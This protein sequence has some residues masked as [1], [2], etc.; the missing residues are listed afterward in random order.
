MA[1]CVYD[2]DNMLLL[3]YEPSLGT[4]MASTK[5]EKH[6][7]VVTHTHHRLDGLAEPRRCRTQTVA[8]Q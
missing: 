8:I 4:P 6:I 7:Q 2:S 5:W 3:F 1:L